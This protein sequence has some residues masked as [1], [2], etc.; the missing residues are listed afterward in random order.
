MT[1]DDKT[2]QQLKRILVATDFSEESDK[3]VDFA[4][5]LVSR[6]NESTLYIVHAVKPS[7]V[8]LSD[9]FGSAEYV[10]DDNNQLLN[11]SEVKANNLASALKQKGIK[12]VNTVVSMGDPVSI[13]I[14]AAEEFKVGL[15]VLGTRKHGFKKGIFFGSV[16]ERV[17]ANSPVSVLVVR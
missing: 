15:I 11:D 5:G 10:I 3:A 4:A 12:N 7:F 8:P 16:S 13:I 1:L 9:D 2:V 6:D 14:N 17:S